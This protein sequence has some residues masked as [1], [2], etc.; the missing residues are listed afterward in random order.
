MA[1][2]AE[3]PKL[4]WF[5]YGH[6][7]GNAAGVVV[8]EPRGLLH[9]RLK[10]SMAGA[11]REL[12]LASGHQLDPLSVER[13]LI[14]KKPPAPLVRRRTVGKRRS[15]NQDPHREACAGALL[16]LSMISANPIKAWPTE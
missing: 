8:I 4:F 10:A 11:D 5:T 9:A 15:A 14:K 16:R 13:M 2:K 12:E 1:K 3:P 7:D 6:S